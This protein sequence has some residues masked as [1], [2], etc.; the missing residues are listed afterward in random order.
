MA[1][2][3]NRQ[4]RF[5][6]H[7]IPIRNVDWVKPII[8]RRPYYHQKTPKDESGFFY[9]GCRVK[10]NVSNMENKLIS[11]I[12]SGPTMN[13]TKPQGFL[14]SE[15][16]VYYTNSADYAIAWP[17]IINTFANWCSIARFSNDP[18]LIVSQTI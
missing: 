10:D 14:S 11:F 9:H 1:K 8:T 13:H 7:F 3:H 2:E 17:T 6:Q 4:I 16:A 12:Q 15:S 18:V 5:C